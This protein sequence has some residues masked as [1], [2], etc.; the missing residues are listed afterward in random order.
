MEATI[1]CN[2]AVFNFERQNYLD[3]VV[4]TLD[5]YILLTKDSNCYILYYSLIVSVHWFDGIICQSYSKP[6]SFW[7]YHIIIAQHIAYIWNVCLMDEHFYPLLFSYKM[8]HFY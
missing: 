6:L 2:V 4:H 3:Y 8:Y 7:R 1:L 5:W